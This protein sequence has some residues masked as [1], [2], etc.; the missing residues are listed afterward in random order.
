[1]EE[2]MKFIPRCKSWAERMAILDATRG[3]AR[4]SAKIFK[5][6]EHELSDDLISVKNCV[7]VWDTDKPLNVGEAGTWYR[8]VWFYHTKNNIKREIIREGTLKTR[9]VCTNPEIVDGKKWPPERLL[10]LDNGTTQLATAAYLMGDERKVQ[11][12]QYYTPKYEKL[13]MTY[14]SV[15]YWEEKNKNNEPWEMRKD[16]T[17][18]RQIRAYLQYLK[19][20]KM[21]FVPR[22]S[23]DYCFAKIFNAMDSE[24]EKSFTSV[25][26]HE[27][28]RT[29]IGEAIEEAE[30]Y[31]KTSSKDHR[32]ITN[33][34]LDYLAKG[35]DLHIE[36]PEHISKAWPSHQF[37]GLVGY[38]I[39]SR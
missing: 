30:K 3:Y 38:I 11:D 29:K 36:H 9:E 28:D 20:G 16:K 8:L 22:H 14:E 5:E 15:P 19:T 2:F 26:T 10:T 1:M 31:H 33:L 25:K 39:T 18:E 21:E 32:I 27:S 6:H 34:V 7:D 13:H 35:I 17:I 24:Q 12:T 23:E 4:N 37:Y